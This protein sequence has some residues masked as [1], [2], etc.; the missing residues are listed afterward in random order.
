MKAQPATQETIQ[1]TPSKCTSGPDCPCEF[2]VSLRAKHA[3][4][5]SEKDIEKQLAEDFLRSYSGK[6]C[7]C[8]CTQAHAEGNSYHIPS[9]R[10]NR[11]P[12]S[13]VVIFTFR[14]M[15]TTSVPFSLAHVQSS[16]TQ[17]FDAM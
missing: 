17:P 16:A 9:I 2:C 4:G 11:L 13:F 6:F 8:M 14:W 3:E 7:G 1:T 10:S 5:R 12:V 15:A